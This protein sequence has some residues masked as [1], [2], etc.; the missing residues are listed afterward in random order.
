MPDYR[1]EQP[2][3]ANGM[4]KSYGTRLD[5]GAGPPS[6][7]KR[8]YSWSRK[9]PRPSP[10]PARPY[11]SGSDSSI[12]SSNSVPGYSPYTAPPSSEMRAP[13]ARPRSNSFVSD[14]SSGTAATVASYD[15][16]NLYT[17]YPGPLRSNT[18][19][20]PQTRPRSDSFGSLASES[21]YSATSTTPYRNQPP[22]DTPVSQKGYNLHTT[23]PAAHTGY[24]LF[25]TP[26]R[27][28]G[29]AQAAPL[30]AD[31]P[32]NSSNGSVPTSR[33]RR[34]LDERA[35][36]SVK[37]VPT[38]RLRQ[39]LDERA[40]ERAV[41]ARTTRSSTSVAV[42]GNTP[43]NV[44]TLGY[45]NPNTPATAPSP[46]RYD[47]PPS[48][49]T[50][51]RAPP[52]HHSQVATTSFGA[53][54]STSTA[55]HPH[56]N[57]FAAEARGAEMDYG[58]Y[59]DST[60][61][62][63]V[64]PYNP[65]TQYDPYQDQ[66]LQQ[67][68]PMPT[69]AT[70]ARMQTAHGTLA[71]QSFQTEESGPGMLEESSPLLG[72]TS[73]YTSGNGRSSIASGGAHNDGYNKSGSQQGGHS[74]GGSGNG[75][76]SYGHSSYGT[77]F[78]GIS[79]GSSYGTTGYGQEANDDGGYTSKNRDP[80]N[81]DHYNSTEVLNDLRPPVPILDQASPIVTPNVD[82]PNEAAIRQ[83]YNAPEMVHARVHT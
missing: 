22:S 4:S 34:L 51:A 72:T 5:Q 20:S 23:S 12:D 32:L 39:L 78:T 79:L 24:N 13:V 10:S 3:L 59:E 70:M 47:A 82:R 28:P 80:R 50:P 66:R 19:G 36:E 54:G 56:A 1:G 83:Q 29:S 64:T 53:H 44:Y 40:A 74:Y 16:Y 75:H 68:T 67:P 26:Q 33:L 25:T 45:P 58:Y 9:S 11:R 2:L 6:T 69:P 14:R 71:L 52:Q 60:Y 76:S 57:P 38:S 15:S 37:A 73:M 81:R 65:V 17:T 62:D 30:V 31:S 7:P 27:V 77:R 49:Y 21:R 41:S 63:P 46:A 48:P 43:S 35:A 42:S 61:Y 8:E 18:R 55:Y